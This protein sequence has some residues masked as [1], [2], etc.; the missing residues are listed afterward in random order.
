LPKVIDLSRLLAG[1]C[2]SAFA[3]LGLKDRFFEA[4]FRASEWDASWTLPLP[5]HRE[6]NTL[7]LFRTVANVFQEGTAFNGTWVGKV[8]TGLLW[9]QTFGTDLAT[10]TRFLRPWLK[11]RTVLWPKHTG[12]HWLLFCLSKCHSSDI[13]ISWSLIFSVSC[14]AL[15]S[16]LDKAFF[17]QY[18]TLVLRVSHTSNSNTLNKSL[19]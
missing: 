8:S 13:Y 16:S 19:A 18:L 15:H 4:L 3:T 2:P 10:L 5:K 1:F 11:Y 7:L 12:W 17:D 6:T 14:V 9:H